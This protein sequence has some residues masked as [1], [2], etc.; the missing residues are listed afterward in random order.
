[1][2]QEQAALEAQKDVAFKNI[3][4]A[5]E[6]NKNKRT[7]VEQALEK[8]TQDEFLLKKLSLLTE[9]NDTL[10]DL[11]RVWNGLLKIVADHKILFF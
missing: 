8:D 4:V 9:T 7:A 1:M 3:A 10:R 11:E 2:T 5:L 6:E